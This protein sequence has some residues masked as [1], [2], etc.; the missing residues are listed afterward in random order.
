MIRRDEAMIKL[1]LRQQRCARTHDS[2]LWPAGETLCRSRDEKGG[3]LSFTTDQRQKQIGDLSV[4]DPLLATIDDV[5]IS[6]STSLSLNSR[7]IATHLRFREG[8]RTQQF[9]PGRDRPHF[10]FQL[11]VAPT[12][13]S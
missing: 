10:R 1:E 4:G 3:Q 8:Q 13:D 7:R 2:A 11:A 12:P 5:A 6:L 9:S